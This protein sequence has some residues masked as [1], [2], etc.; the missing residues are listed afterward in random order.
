MTSPVPNF[1]IPE[2][3]SPVASKRKGVL[4]AK[5]GLDGHDRG[6]KYVAQLLRDAGYEVAYTGIRRTPAEIVDAAIERNVA[7][8]G[9][10]LLSGAHNTLF[11]EVVELLRRRGAAGV[12][13]LGGGVIPGDDIPRLLSA[14]VRAV[15]TPGATAAEILKAFAEAV[16]TPQPACDAYTSAAAPPRSL[17][18]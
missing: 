12:A 5:P 2:A 6:A 1:W 10:S 15:F 8:V 7:A 4:I 11:V 13:V 9:L 18:S 14:G 16:G 3:V 17:A